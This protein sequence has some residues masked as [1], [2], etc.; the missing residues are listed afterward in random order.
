MCFGIDIYF[1]SIP[2]QSS[3]LNA[4]F[5]NIIYFLNSTIETFVFLYFNVSK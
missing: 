3:L 1:L 2:L 5:T 4:L